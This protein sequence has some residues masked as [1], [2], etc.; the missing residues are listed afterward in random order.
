MGAEGG[1]LGAK[2]TT[3]FFDIIFVADPRFPGGTSTALAS[4]VR[5]AHRAGLTAALKPIHSTI[6]RRARP[7][8]PDLVQSLIETDTPI[9][10]SATAASCRFALLHHP[11][12]FESIPAEPLQITADTAVLIL[13]HPPREADGSQSY[14]PAK[15]REMAALM[16]GQDPWLAPVGPAVRERLD[17]G[18]AKVVAKDWT[19]LID[20]KDWPDQSE[21]I[22]APLGAKLRVGRHSR[23]H[24]PKWPDTLDKAL[25]AYP[26]SADLSVSMLGADPANLRRRYGSLPAHWTTLPFGSVAVADY[27][28]T[29]DAWVYFHGSDW[30]EAFGRAI[31]EAAA[32]GLPVIVPPVFRKL[33]GPAC[34][35]CEPEDVLGVL[36]NLRR[37]D[38]ARGGQA[39]RARNHIAK[40]YGIENYVTRL[41]ALDPVWA[42]TRR[43]SR[44]AEPA[45]STPL[46]SKAVT[47]V[48]AKPALMM[49]SNGVG[50]G[51]L[52]RLLAIAEASAA[53]PSPAFFTLSRGAE[54]VRKAGF[55]C[56]FSPFHR[57]L[58][59]DVEAWNDNLTLSLLEAADFHGSGTFVF[60]GNMPYR[61]VL[62][63]LAA[64]PEIR[65][66][67]CRR[68]MWRDSHDE[69]LPRGE[70]FDLILAPGDI[71]GLLD[72][73][74]TQGDAASNIIEVPPIWRDLR[75]LRLDREAALR[76]LELDASGRYV[77][78]S[79]GSMVN[80]DLGDLPA[81]IV[82]AVLRGGETPVILRSPLERDSA[83]LKD[84]VGRVE[85]R[86]IYPIM[87]YLAA[88]DY[89]VS[90][91]GYNSFH[92]FTAVGLPTIWV[93][94][95]AGEMDRQD[96]RARF[97]SLAKTGTLLRNGDTSRVG[98]VV[99]GLQDPRQRAIMAQ[100]ALNLPLENGAI[101]AANILNMLSCMT[102]MGR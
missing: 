82:E 79:L 35:Y 96:L 20:I 26:S 90:A 15:I 23:P 95:E 13:H 81:L 62:E 40:Q 10:G 7:F 50:L 29:L 42:K 99:A 91:A 9:L 85:H 6:I 59:I 49:S 39:A 18:D 60:D 25:A 55:A 52:T 14:A 31:L 19:N 4:E 57:G 28:A 75:R 38:V 102:M 30:V 3:L 77:L 2:E 53:T 76:R 86:Q 89:A 66:V 92:E 47:Y 5:A 61:G 67:W 73:G 84:F 34:I 74:P 16:I 68:G 36:E 22:A 58:D 1:S 71:A 8:H 70:S 88:F 12:V 27:L 80:H 24:P 11:M 17:A 69:A 48:G 83:A 46:L 98:E 63:F 43:A 94:N 101:A 64:R 97:A 41:E 93:P 51:H 44:R 32:S 21:R 45:L 87:P 72:H 100:R 78:F 65:S 37:D 33:F 56:E 54:F